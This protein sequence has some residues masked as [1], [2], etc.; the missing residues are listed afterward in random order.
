M[1]RANG[2]VDI[3]AP[4]NVVWNWIVEPEKYLAWN[5]DFSEYTVVEERQDKV[6][7]LY[8][9]VGEKAGGPIKLDCVVTEWVVNER[10]SFRGTSKDG[11]K[12]EG[13]FTIEPTAEGRRVAFEEDLELPG[14][15][16]KIIEVLFL[17]KAKMKN[18]EESLQKLKKAVE[19]SL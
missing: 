13:T 17:K 2:A 11:T 10:F 8:Y 9:V 12:A 5:P 15:K 14:V 18:I 19:E 4:A 6:G 7:T 1:T 16:G 3:A